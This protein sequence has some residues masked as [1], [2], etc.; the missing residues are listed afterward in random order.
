MRTVEVLRLLLNKIFIAKTTK[1]KQKE[2]DVCTCG[3]TKEKLHFVNNLS[4]FLLLLFLLCWNIKLCS[5][6]LMV[7]SWINKVKR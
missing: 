2:F 5:Q 3:E 1:Q 6:S 4:F 7:K